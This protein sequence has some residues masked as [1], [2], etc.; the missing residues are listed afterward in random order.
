MKVGSIK[1]QIFGKGAPDLQLIMDAF[2]TF[3]F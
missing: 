2:K 1:T 3:T